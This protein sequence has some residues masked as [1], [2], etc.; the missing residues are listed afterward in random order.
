VVPETGRFARAD[1]LRD[2]RDFNRISRSG[3][4]VASSEFVL[5]ATAGE[6]AESRRL[7]ISVSRKVG[8][9]VV[10]NR[11]KRGVRDW[12]RRQ[13][14]LLPESLDLVVIARPKAKRLNGGAAIDLALEKTWA[15][16]KRQ[17]KTPFQR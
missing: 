11:I 9:A 8:N 6:A 2:S 5:L 3:Q 4:R 16:A 14:G 12:F 10:R 15:R 1:R 7:G 17:W 13:R